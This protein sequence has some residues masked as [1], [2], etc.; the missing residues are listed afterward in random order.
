M[1]DQVFVAVSGVIRGRGLEGVH[2]HFRLCFLQSEIS[3][4]ILSHPRLRTQ[5]RLQSKI[6]MSD[7][8]RVP[9][10]VFSQAVLLIFFLIKIF[11]TFV[12]VKLPDKRSVM[13]SKHLPFTL[14]G[15]ASE[16]P[17]VPFLLNFE[18][19]LCLCYAISVKFRCFFNYG[20]F[21]TTF[22]PQS[23][24]C[25]RLPQNVFLVVKKIKFFE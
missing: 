5:E 22:P 2:V 16:N 3:T 6:K 12:I 18:I 24:L 9:L 17:V 21:S 8:C 4:V 13:P 15:K 11:S 10:T 1:R 14:F 20:H 23:H 7:P 19:I 25:L